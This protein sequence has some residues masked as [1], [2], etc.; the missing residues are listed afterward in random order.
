MANGGCW[1]WIQPTD[2]VRRSVEVRAKRPNS[3]FRPNAVIYARMFRRL[4]LVIYWVL[5]KTPVTARIL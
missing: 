3:G 2:A 4:L 1:L 5:T